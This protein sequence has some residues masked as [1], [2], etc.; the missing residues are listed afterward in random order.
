[1]CIKTIVQFYIVFVRARHNA[2][3]VCSST[4]TH[5]PL[6]ITIR[7]PRMLRIRQANRE[8][9]L[10]LLVAQAH[11]MFIHATGSKTSPVADPRGK[12]AYAS[13]VALIKHCDMRLNRSRTMEK[14]RGHQ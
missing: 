1:M 9:D 12:A 13:A 14:N 11:A 6:M 3:T 8:Y 5:F 10:N 4:H 2:I 7:R